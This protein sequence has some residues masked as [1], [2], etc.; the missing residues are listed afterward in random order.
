MMTFSQGEALQLFSDGY[1]QAAFEW[2]RGYTLPGARLD[3]YYSHKPRWWKMGY[4]RYALEKQYMA[5]LRD[6]MRDWEAT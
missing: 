2:P 3:T 4:W 6:H 5:S 1:E